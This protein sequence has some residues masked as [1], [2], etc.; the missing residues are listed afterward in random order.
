MQ[1]FAAD[2]QGKHFTQIANHTSAATL[3]VIGVGMG[4][5]RGEVPLH[6]RYNAVM[7]AAARTTL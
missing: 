4:R 6:L 2:V 7:G 5:S 3:G 1:I